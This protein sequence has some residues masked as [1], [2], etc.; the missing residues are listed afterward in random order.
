MSGFSLVKP[1]SFNTGIDVDLS[2]TDQFGN[3]INLGLVKNWD[4]ESITHEV[5]DMPINLKGAPIQTDTHHGARG[6]FTIDRSNGDQEAFYQT[7]VAAYRNGQ[8]QIY[9]TI[10][11]TIQNRAT[12]GAPANVYQFTPA[13]VKLNKT[14]PFTTDSLVEQAVVWRSANWFI[15]V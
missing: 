13:V 14:G 12:P 7:I 8:G 3:A 1:V 15:V 11:A 9:A 2:L 5:D 4:W 10:T 6:T